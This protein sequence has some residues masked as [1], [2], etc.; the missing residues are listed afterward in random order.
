MADHIFL[1][2][3]NIE[4][5]DYYCEL[6]K[7]YLD[8]TEQYINFIKFYLDVADE[9]VQELEE[10]NERDEKQ[11]RANNEDIQIDKNTII[12]I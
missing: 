6:Y 12:E 9:Y 4:E 7:D 1:E 5:I 2:K 11:T 8:V 3:Y 10:S